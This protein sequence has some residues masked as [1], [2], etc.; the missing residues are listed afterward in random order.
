MKGEQAQ[1]YFGSRMEQFVDED[2][3]LYQKVVDLSTEKSEKKKNLDN[4]RTFL[5]HFK[6]NSSKIATYITSNLGHILTC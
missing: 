4:V 1:E 6:W 2:N 3:Y 5:V